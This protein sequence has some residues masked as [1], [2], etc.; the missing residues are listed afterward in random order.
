M[1][2]TNNNQDNQVHLYHYSQIV[3]RPSEAT[4][5]RTL[6]KPGQEQGTEEVANR[7]TT[8][9]L[10]QLEMSTILNRTRR[11]IFRNADVLSTEETYSIKRKAEQIDFFRSKAYKSRC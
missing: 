10:E 9:F 3:K 7:R 6:Q 1:E 4:L 2:A 11:F 8:L 5:T